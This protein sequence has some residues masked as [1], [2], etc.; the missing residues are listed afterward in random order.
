MLHTVLYRGSQAAGASFA[1]LPIVP[2]SNDVVANNRWL[3]PD[4][5]ELLFA[6]SA[7]AN[8]S[9]SRIQTPL[10]IQTAS[11]HLEPVNNSA[12]FPTDCNIIDF[13]GNPVQFRKT[14]GVD[15]QTSNAGGAAENHVV[16]LFFGD[17][18]YDRI[19]GPRVRVRATSS[20]AVTAGVWTR[21]PIVFDESLPNRRFGVVGMDVKSAT[22][23]VARLD[24]PGQAL[25]P[26]TLV[27]TGNG[28]RIPYQMSEQYAGVLGYFTNQATPSLEIFCTA[29]DTSAQV[30]LDLIPVG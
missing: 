2:F 19:A 17:K 27:G 5:T 14:E 20:T 7:G 25:R 12:T 28:F 1:S 9:Q 10:I 11:L 23:I 3:P 16:V 26:G 30:F 22:G 4:D 29:A 15:V 24:I 21:V 8:M 18:R 13:T 6:A